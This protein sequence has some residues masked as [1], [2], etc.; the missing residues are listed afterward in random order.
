MHNKFQTY[1]LRLSIVLPILL[2]GSSLMAQQPT[3]DDKERSKRFRKY[4]YNGETYLYGQLDD[5][6]ITAKAPNAW[7]RR[8]GNKR[9]Q[10][11]TRLQ[12]NVHKVYPYALKV[13]DVLKEV[14]AHMATLSTQSEK[15]AYLK[16][17]ESGLFGEYEDD[18][19]KMSRSQGKVLV[20]L[21]HRQTGISAY[22]LI[23][24]NKSSAAAVFWQGISRIFG[25]NLKADYDQE[26][27]EMIED[28]VKG[29]ETGG[30]NIYYKRYNY[31]LS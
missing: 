1:L 30:Y 31:R 14:D 7:Q 6:D 5:I 4:E 2:L 13:S 15:D 22:D 16:E 9:L 8:R 28:I 20:K 10:R 26:A 11:Y 23:K 24:L 18:V 12:W 17:R 19:R 3:E 27:E 25:I 21:I 29:L